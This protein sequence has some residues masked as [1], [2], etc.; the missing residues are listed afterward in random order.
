MYIY[1]RCLEWYMIEEH[2]PWPARTLP[3]WVT[4]S[5]LQPWMSVLLM[6]FSAARVVSPYCLIW[7]DQHAGAVAVHLSLDNRWRVIAAPVIK[8]SIGTIHYNVDTMGERFF[9]EWQLLLVKLKKHLVKCL[10]SVTFF[11]FHQVWIVYHECHV[12]TECY[13]RVLLVGKYKFTECFS[14]DTR[15]RCTIPSVFNH[16]R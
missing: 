5:F 12:V 8:Q 11:C 9:T 15:W 14:F 3:P 7:A 2:S 6:T 13:T 1:P 16:T 4:P 10:P